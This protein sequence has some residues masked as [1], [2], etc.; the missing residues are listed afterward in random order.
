MKLLDLRN[1]GHLGLSAYVELGELTE[2][3]VVTFVLRTPPDCKYGNGS[4]SNGEGSGEEGENCGQ[5][6]MVS[7]RRATE[8][9][10]DFNGPWMSLL[11]LIFN[12]FDILFNFIQFTLEA[13]LQLLQFSFFPQFAS[14]I[15]S[16][17]AHLDLIRGTSKLRRKDDP[18]LT[19]VCS[20]F[21]TP[22]LH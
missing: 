15:K 9:G 8:M 12:S 21:S 3:Q 22:L 1:K 11:V 18:I 7:K 17:H 20:K 4:N 5:D 19:A 10:V 2:G 6:R 13:F 14:R 16:E